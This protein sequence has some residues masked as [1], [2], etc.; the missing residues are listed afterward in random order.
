MNG[1]ARILTGTLG[2]GNVGNIDVRVGRLTLMGGAIINTNSGTIVGPRGAAGRAGDLT[3]L[4]TES[5]TIA[6]RDAD[7]NSRLASGT[8]A[9][10][11][12]GGNIFIAT[13]SL[14]I[15][16]GAILATTGAG[17]SRDAGNILLM[18]DRLTLTG[19]ARISAASLTG[20][21]GRGGN[22]RVNATDSISISGDRDGFRSGIASLTETSGNAGNLFISAATVN[23][24]HG[25]SYLRTVRG[26]LAMRGT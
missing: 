23:M 21:T 13:P 17:G 20:S 8:T 11:G 18:V 6:G 25:G 1:P 2:D 19:G 16:D 9:G 10:G 5:I 14:N 4:A 26:E 24:Y 3:V 15:D 22:I 7:F 12:K